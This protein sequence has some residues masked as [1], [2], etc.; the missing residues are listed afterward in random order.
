MEY[1]LFNKLFC[2][3]CGMH[4]IGDSGTSKGGEKH[5]Y[6]TC[7]NRKKNK[8]CKKKSEKKDYLEWYVVEQTLKYVLTPQRMDII[9]ASVVA[10]YDKEFNNSRLHDMEKRL[11]K[12]DRDIKKCFDM[13]V[14]T[15]S[16]ACFVNKKCTNAS[17]MC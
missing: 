13:M 16:R 17:K 9:A 8:A 3:Y 1:L 4:M 10:E 2:G 7:Y 11:T 6:Y 14:E 12:I 5:Y 15:N